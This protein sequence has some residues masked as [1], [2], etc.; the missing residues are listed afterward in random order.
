LTPAAT[1]VAAI[2]TPASTVSAAA[3]RLRCG[4][5][6]FDDLD[7]FIGDA[8]VFD[9]NGRRLVSDYSSARQD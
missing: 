9:L 7:D 4:L 8:E 1:T 3:L 5:L 2:S 6:L